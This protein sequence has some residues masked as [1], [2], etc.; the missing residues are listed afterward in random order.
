MFVRVDPERAGPSA[1]G[2]LIPP[3]RRTLIALR[4]KTLS[5]DLLPALWDADPSH[6]PVFCQF[7]REEA[8]AIARKLVQT[9]EDAVANG[10]NPLETFGHAARPQLWLRTPH[11]VWI[12]C[13]RIQGEGYRP[14]VFDS[15][16]EACAAAE[17]IAAFVWPKSRQEV[18]F[19]T[20]R[21]EENSI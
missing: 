11:H 9:L 12:V 4:P 20:Q 21:F 14:V 19:N 13:R 7:T 15:M 17:G 2:I 5:W 3:G 16:D 6:A 18:Y 8:P 1:L 10:V